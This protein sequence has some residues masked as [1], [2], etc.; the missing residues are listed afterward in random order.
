MIYMEP[1]TLGWLPFVESWI[2]TL[3]SDWREGREKYVLD[4]CNWIVPP[5]VHFINKNCIQFCKPG[6]ISLVR[7]MMDMVEMFMNEAM[8]SGTKKEE[9]VKYIEIWIQASF[10][11][12]GESYFHVRKN[13]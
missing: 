6:D 4:M 12:A 8:I 3:N 5:C 9:Q 10:M 7:N 13:T 1:A 11:Q 2:P